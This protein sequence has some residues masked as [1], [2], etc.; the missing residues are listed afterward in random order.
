[1]AEFKRSVSHSFALWRHKKSRANENV[2][3]KNWKNCEQN[4]FY[5]PLKVSSIGLNFKACQNSIAAPAAQ[6]TGKANVFVV[7]PSYGKI[8]SCSSHL[9]AD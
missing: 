3:A 4:Q 1:L 5:I 2:V 8:F 7:F 6:M 9:M